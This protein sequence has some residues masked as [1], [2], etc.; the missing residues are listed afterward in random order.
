MHIFLEIFLL[1]SVMITLVICSTY[2]VEFLTR[3]PLFKSDK[4][5]FIVFLIRFFIIALGYVYIIGS[6]AETWP[7]EHCFIMCRKFFG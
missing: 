2:L 1:I 5:Y 6:Y 4:S 7:D 3:F